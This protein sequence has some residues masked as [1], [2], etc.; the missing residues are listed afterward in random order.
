MN[1]LYLA[2]ITV[3]STALTLEPSNKSALAVIIVACI[4]LI[5]YILYI[6]AMIKYSVIKVFAR[7]INSLKKF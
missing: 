5:S 4:V 3:S 1:V 6:L 2:L 7:G